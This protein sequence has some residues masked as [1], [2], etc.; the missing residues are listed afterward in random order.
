MPLSALVLYNVTMWLY[1]ITFVTIQGKC[2]FTPVA[3]S[4]LLQLKK[5]KERRKEKNVK[6]IQSPQTTTNDNLPPKLSFMA[7]YPRNYQ[8]QRQCTL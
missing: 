8:K 3:I 5:K 1:L 4:P 2:Y 7:I 6:S